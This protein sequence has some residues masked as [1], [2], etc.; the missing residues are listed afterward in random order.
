MPVNQVLLHYGV[1]MAA[2]ATPIYCSI[3]APQSMLLPWI[4]CYCTVLIVHC[5]QHPPSPSC[6]YHFTV[7][8]QA[9]ERGCVSVVQFIMLHNIFRYS[10]WTI[11][12]TPARRVFFGDTLWALLL[13]LAAFSFSLAF[14]V[15]P[16]LF[17]L[18]CLIHGSTLVSVSCALA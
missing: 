17:F 16:P 12:D 13:F 8:L 14:S 11:E 1:R 3:M 7:A 2:K 5:A 18:G 15:L 9:N 4:T 10:G 6:T